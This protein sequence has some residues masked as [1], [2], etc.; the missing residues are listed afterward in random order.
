MFCLF[1]VCADEGS[2]LISI[3]IEVFVSKQ[4]DI[5]FSLSRSKSEKL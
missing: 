4:K 2:I 5:Y 3:I 1:V